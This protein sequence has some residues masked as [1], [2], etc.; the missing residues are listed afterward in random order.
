MTSHP[1]LRAL[2]SRTPALGAWLTLPGAAHARLLA[3]SSAHLSWLVVDCEHGLVPLQAGAADAVAAIAGAGVSPL[4][5]VPA[6]G[7]SGAGGVGWQIKYALDVGARGVV[8]PMVNT[9]DQASLVAREARFPPAGVRGF[10]SPFTHGIWGTSAGAYLAGANG[11]VLVL[12][13][14]ET[15]EAVGNLEAIAAVEGV[16]VLFIG[17]FDL[18]LSLGFPTPSPD[19]HP[20]VEKVIQHILEVGHA[21]NKKVAIFCTSGAQAV[22]RA[23]QG[24]DMVNV[25]ADTNVLTQG[26]ASELAIA[27]GQTQ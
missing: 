9:A 20:E 6:T 13:Q 22:N 8:V 2:Q 3:Q 27:A 21:A 14:I 25:T 5:R 17:P 16:D 4:V 1:L 24:F 11:S 15:R 10:G 12:V 26:M 23:K 7:A 19:P 18:S